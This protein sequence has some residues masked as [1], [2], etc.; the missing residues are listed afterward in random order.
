MCWQGSNNYQRGV[1]ADEFAIECEGIMVDGIVS[2]D[3]SASVSPSQF[4]CYKSYLNAGGLIRLSDVSLFRR[5]RI[6]LR[7]WRTIDWTTF[8]SPNIG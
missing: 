2:F 5:A 1:A 3:S 6:G 8:R 7:A 4:S